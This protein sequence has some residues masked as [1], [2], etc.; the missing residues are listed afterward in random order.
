M[1]RFEAFR[2]LRYAPA[3]APLERLIAPPYDVVDADERACLAARS[4]YNSIRLELPAADPGRGLDRYQAAAALLASWRAAGVLVPDPNPSLY[5]YK[6]GFLDD[7][8]GARSTTGVIGALGLE[9]FGGAVVP[10]EQTMAAPGRDR[11][12][13]LRACEINFSPIWGLSLASGLSAACAAASTRADEHLLAV[14]D[15]STTHEMWRV[16]DEDAI[17]AITDLVAPAAVVIAD[18]HHRHETAIRYRAE[19]VA[20]HHGPSGCGF[21]MAY[22][23]ELAPDE[24]SVQAIHRVVTGLPDG[25]DLLGALGGRF[26]LERTSDDP[27]ALAAEMV[28]RGAPALVLVAGSWLLFPTAGSVAVDELDS[29]RVDEALGWLPRHRTDYQHGTARAVDAVRDGRAQ[30]AVLVRPATIDQLAATVRAGVRMPPKSTYFHPKPRTG[31]V[32]RAL[33]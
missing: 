25:F 18:G 6:M 31:F 17:H 3:I 22:V 2:G 13:L 4:P 19:C 30:A 15:D 7:A 23:A 8:G 29:R 9:P 26:R 21:V 33:A 10:H 14:D 32:F 5:V 1:P 28:A 11:L 16:D 24:L 20:R 12:D 27:A